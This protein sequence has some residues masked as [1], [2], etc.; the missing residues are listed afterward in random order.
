MNA[1]KPSNHVEVTLFEAHE[2]DKKSEVP[3]HCSALKEHISALCVHNQGD[4]VLVT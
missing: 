3:D 2:F 4:Y 1:D